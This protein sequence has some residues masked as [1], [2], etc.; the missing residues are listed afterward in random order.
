MGSTGS[1]NFSDYSGTKKENQGNGAS[2]GSS[3]GDRCRQ[4]FDAGLEDV[5]QYAYYTNS[6]TVPPAGTVLSL[7]HATRIIAIDGNGTEIGAL[8]TK[9]NYLAS[10]LRD[11]VQYSGIVTASTIGTNPQV[12][13]DFAAI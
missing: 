12:N 9:F 13:V 4:A 11:G 3:G 10:C 8:P 6:N 5:A 1:G 2:G 7:I